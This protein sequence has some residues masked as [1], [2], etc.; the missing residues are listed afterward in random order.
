VLGW[1]Y[2][3]Q[4]QELMNAK[5]SGAYEHLLVSL[6]SD[7]NQ[8]VKKEAEGIIND[9]PKTPYA[10]QS[11][12]VLARLAVYEGDYDKAS[13]RLNWVIKES[14]IPSLQEAARLRL[15]RVQIAEKNYD[16]ALKT[17]DTID[18]P[19][20]KMAVYE[21]RGDALVAK[22]DRKGAQTAYRA[23]LDELSKA[24][25]SYPLLQMKYDDLVGTD[26]VYQ[27]E[28]STKQK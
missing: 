9:Y 26:T 27:K 22:G 3:K 17:L 10:Q 21:L 14:K 8:A 25:F 6:E 19:A 11:A 18:D 7:N 4:H 23:A 15:A 13:E 5:A 2:W 16:E 28:T 1:G 20:Y 24:D 12:M